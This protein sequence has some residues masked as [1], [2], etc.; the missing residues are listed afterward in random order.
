MEWWQILILAVLGTI[1]T[2]AL[3]ALIIWR[4]ATQRTRTLGRRIGKLPWRSKLELA[5]RL[6]MDDRMPLMVRILPAVLV[7]YLALPL[8]LIPDFIPLISR[9]DDLAVVVIALDLFME[10]VPRELMIEKLYEL[11]IDGRELERDMEAVRRFV[12]SPIRAAARRLPPALE[13]GM[14]LLDSRFGTWLARQKPGNK[15]PQE[16]RPA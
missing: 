2:L 9:L 13:R 6:V 8:D 12:P 5:G 7:L 10:G 11:D 4:M 1:A 14:E 15:E 16:D 3:A